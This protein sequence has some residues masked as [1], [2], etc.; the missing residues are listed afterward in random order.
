MNPTV[1]VAGDAMLDQYWRG[2]IERISPEA[3]VPV[4]AVREYEQRKGAAAN[5]AANLRAM[6]C[7]VREAY[8]PSFDYAPIEKIR[9]VARGQHI[10]RVDIDRPQEAIDPADVAALVDGCDVVV[11]S[12]YG[13]GALVRL[14]EC[15][16][17]CRGRGARILVDPKGGDLSRYAGADLV[18]PNLSEMRALVGQW[19]DDFDLNNR[20]QGVMDALHVTYFL[21]TRGADGM[22]LFAHGAPPLHV[23]AHQREVFDVCGAGDT[24]IAACAAALAR[25]FPIVRAVEVANR[26]AGLAVTRFG[27]A[28]V[29]AA[30][31]FECA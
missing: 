24:A 17:A 15:I 19:R 18:K 30:E 3:P 28:V 2:D 4:V 12:D 1:L 22:S 21:L 23:T 8:S 20:L 29:T 27:T 9:V 26:A 14:P 16:A 7:E 13:K 11:F 31:A 10:A 25:G 6:G 5:V